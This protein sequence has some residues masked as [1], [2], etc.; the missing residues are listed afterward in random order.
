MSVAQKF[1]WLPFTQTMLSHLLSNFFTKVLPST[2]PLQYQSQLPHNTSLLPDKNTPEHN[3]SAIPQHSR[4]GVAPIWAEGASDIQGRN[5]AITSMRDA[6]G[7]NCEIGY[8]SSLAPITTLEA[9]AP[10]QVASTHTRTHT[11]HQHGPR[12]VPS[13]ANYYITYTEDVLFYCS[14]VMT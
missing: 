9:P 6:Y 8:T 2:T 4:H 5:L 14:V 3:K 11:A 10:V 1:H 13:I 12:V 7:G